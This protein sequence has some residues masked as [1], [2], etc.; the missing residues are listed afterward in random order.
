[1]TDM[2]FCKDCFHIGSGEY[3]LCKNPK[4]ARMFTDPITGIESLQQPFCRVERMFGM[5]HMCGPEGKY[6]TQKIRSVT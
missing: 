1:M 4:T 3:P 6:F 5:E 2:K